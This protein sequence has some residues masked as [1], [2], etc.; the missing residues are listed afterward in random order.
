M[1]LFF[2][3]GIVVRDDAPCVRVDHPVWVVPGL[4]ILRLYILGFVHWLHLHVRGESAP[5][6]VSQERRLP[7]QRVLGGHHGGTAGLHTPV[8]QRQTCPTAP[9]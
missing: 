8:L 1:V 3:D 9:I 4:T 7:D 6:S 2:S 5:E